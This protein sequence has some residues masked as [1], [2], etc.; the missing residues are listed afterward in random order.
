MHRAHVDELLCHAGQQ[1]QGLVHDAHGPKEIDERRV[2]AVA[3]VVFADHFPSASAVQKVLQLHRSVRLHLLDDGFEGAH[4][5]GADRVFGE[6]VEQALHQRMSDRVASSGQRLL[7]AAAVRIQKVLFEMHHVGGQLVFEVS[8]VFAPAAQK[9]DGEAVFRVGVDDLVDPARNPASDV[10]ICALQH[11][12]DVGRLS[13]GVGHDG[14]QKSITGRR[15]GRALHWSR[16]C[17]SARVCAKS[18]RPKHSCAW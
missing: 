2:G 11:Q 13:L 14:F 5:L 1:P 4:G 7:V 12:R 6:G 9:D 3:T 17:I 18:R 10:G 15:R 8:V 16:L